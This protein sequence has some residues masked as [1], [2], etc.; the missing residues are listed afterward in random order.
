MLLLHVSCSPPEAVA[1]ASRESIPRSTGAHGLLLLLLHLHPGQEGPLLWG[2]RCHRKSTLL[3]A[4]FCARKSPDR[5]V[6]EAPPLTASALGF[7][8]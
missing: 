5:W 6:M 3:T 8:G 7:R 1:S 4:L 2:W